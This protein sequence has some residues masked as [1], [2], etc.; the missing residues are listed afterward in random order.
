MDGQAG[1]KKKK[2]YWVRGRAKRHKGKNKLQD[3]KKDKKKTLTLFYAFFENTVS[4]VT[5][6][7]HLHD[8]IHIYQCIQSENQG[9]TQN[10]Q[11]FILG[12]LRKIDKLLRQDT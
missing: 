2:K 4:P 11:I 5:K 12:G 9:N 8:D 6:T 10:L 1:K 3:K 7:F